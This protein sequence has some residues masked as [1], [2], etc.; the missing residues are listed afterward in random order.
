M[1]VDLPAPP[2]A[3]PPDD[4]PKPPPPVAPEDL[5]EVSDERDDKK[6]PRLERGKNG[7]LVKG[8]R[9]LPGAGRPHESA[10]NARRALRDAKA[11]TR[12]KEIGA[13]EVEALPGQIEALKLLM[14]RGY[15][16]VVDV[17]THLHLMAGAADESERGGLRALT[18]SEL[19]AMA[20]QLALPPPKPML[21][22]VPGGRKDDDVVEGEI[23]ELEPKG[24]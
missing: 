14:D 24:E 11:W 23:V 5:N 8:H 22:Y 17:Q 21:E 3:P 15:G 7:K 18:A 19:T 13:G 6:L 20:R 4:P 16:K 9:V 2:P 10:R 1:G 12:L